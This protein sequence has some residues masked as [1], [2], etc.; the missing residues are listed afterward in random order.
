V[1]EG[2]GMVWASLLEELLKVVRGRPCMA[3]AVAC[4]SRDMHHTGAACLLVVATVIVGSGCGLLKMQLAP[5]PTTL[6]TLP[7]VLEG[8][9]E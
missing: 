2:V 1:L 4:G 7:G 6:G 9:V 8:D 5:L 3:L